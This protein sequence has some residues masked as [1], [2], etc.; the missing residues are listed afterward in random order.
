ME[1]GTRETRGDEVMPEFYLDIETYSPVKPIDFNKDP[2]ISVAYQQID[3]KT[4]K[5]LGP[6]TILKSWES[7]EKEM[8]TKFYNIFNVANRWAFIPIGYK[9]ADFDFVMMGTHFRKYGLNI[10]ATTLYNHPYID[11][12]PVA[13]LC[14]GG[15]FKGC[16]LQALAGKQGSGASISDWYTKKD[17][18]AI[19]FYIKDEAKSFINLYSYFVKNMPVMFQGF[20][21][22]TK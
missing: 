18:S 8:L 13:L 7:S 19:E 3:G 12:Y 9:L 17:Y 20:K 4:G 6:L 21:G 11:L 1:S 14:N 2:I 5:E 15:E 16:S 10:S 22:G